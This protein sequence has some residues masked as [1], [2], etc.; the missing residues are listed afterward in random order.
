MSKILIDL[1]HSIVDE[2]AGLYEEDDKIDID[3]TVDNVVFDR[4]SE[5]MTSDN[6]AIAVIGEI[7][8]DI[9]TSGNTLFREIQKASEDVVRGHV[10]DLIKQDPRFRIEQEVQP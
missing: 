4:I 3:D 9:S 2:I 10:L 7:E 1:A 5:T 8:L 6:D